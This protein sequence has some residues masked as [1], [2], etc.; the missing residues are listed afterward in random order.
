MMEAA[1]ISETSVNFY[2]TTRRHNPE[3]SH[4]A[5]RTSN[6]AYGIQLIEPLLPGIYMAGMKTHMKNSDLNPVSPGCEA[7]STSLSAARHSVT[8]GQ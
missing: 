1:G 3:D 6:T 5:V 2:Q 7:G 8:K 4:L